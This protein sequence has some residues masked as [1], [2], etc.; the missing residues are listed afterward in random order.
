MRSGLCGV[1]EHTDGQRWQKD[2]ERKFTKLEMTNEHQVR[3]TMR[4]EVRVEFHSFR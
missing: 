3:V 4:E 2:C 1:I